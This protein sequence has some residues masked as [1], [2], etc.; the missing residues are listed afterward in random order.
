M[1]KFINTEIK[2]KDIYEGVV[3]DEANEEPKA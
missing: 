3:F 2:L 1:L